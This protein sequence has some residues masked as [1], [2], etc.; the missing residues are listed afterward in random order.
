M[1]FL[2]RAVALTTTDTVVFTCPA[3]QSGSAHGLVFSNI[4][5]SAATVSLKLF[6][7]A[8]GTTTTITSALSVAANVPVSWPKPINMIAG[9]QIIASASI[10]S[11]I[12][13]LVSLY[14]S[15]SAPAT[16]GLTPRGT[17]SSSAN[18]AVNDL[19]TLSGTSYIAVVANT[20]STPPSTNWMVLAIK[21]DTGLTGNTGAQGNIGNTG[22]TGNTG[23]TGATGAAGA[24]FTGGTLTSALLVA[25]NLVTQAM[26]KDCGYVAVD[27]GNSGTATVTFDYT[28]GSKQ[29]VTAT[30]AHS[31]AF[32]NWPPSGNEGTM[33][34]DFINYGAFVITPPAITWTNPDGSETTS[35]SAHFTALAAAGGR[36]GFTASG[37][38]K[39]I[40]WCADSSLVYGKFI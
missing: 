32:S 4:T 33:R 8:S 24:T 31:F 9:D 38:T 18:Y 6:S 14:L 21:G 34:V 7:Q 37:I 10:G 12:V 19:V 25:D 20:A 3:T 28:A 16:A 13:A 1:S 23:A 5:G 40:F 29:N 27:K 39:A 17:H 35:L 36:S 22:P 15:S 11:T 30:G 2:E 26:M